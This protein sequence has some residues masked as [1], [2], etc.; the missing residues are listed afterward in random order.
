MSPAATASR[1]SA[2][3]IYGYARGAGFSPAQAVTATA[4]ALAESGGRPTAHADTSIEDS[5]GLWQINVRAHPQFA[6][7][8]LYDPATNARAAYQVSN[9]GQNFV[10]WSTYGTSAQYGTGHTDSYAQ[11]LGTANAAAGGQVLGGQVQTS[12][13]DASSGG[14]STAVGFGWNPLNWGDDLAHV[15]IMGTLVLGGTALVVIGL[16]R[17]VQPTV[18][19]V[20][21]VA[22][23]AA[24]V[25]KVAAV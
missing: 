16:Y 9:G 5:R 3:D 14:G 8:N 11:F 13:S 19:K 17:T 23:K 20:A 4:I 22:G 1:L 21:N 7:W 25:A 2:S 15:A 6:G 18:Q 12:G 10:P 24:S